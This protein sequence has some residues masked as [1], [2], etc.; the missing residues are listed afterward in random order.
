MEKNKESMKNT[1]KLKNYRKYKPQK[2]LAIEFLGYIRYF[3]F[4]KEFRQASY[5]SRL[6]SASL[7]MSTAC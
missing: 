5:R 7:S 1:S 6:H 2:N 4:I 3:Y